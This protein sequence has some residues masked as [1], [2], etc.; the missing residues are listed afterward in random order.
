MSYDEGPATEAI[1]LIRVKGALDERW[2][3]W[4][5]GVEMASEQAIDGSPVT[6]LTGTLDHAALHGVLDR[7]RDLNLTLI[8]LS[9]LEQGPGQGCARIERKLLD[10]VEKGGLEM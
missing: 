4:F 3:D 2:S 7:L 10:G 5:G 6:L 8:S 1:Y 9:R